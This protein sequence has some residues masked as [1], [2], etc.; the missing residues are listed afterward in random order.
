[1]TTKLSR[2]TR[3]WRELGFSLRVLNRMQFSAPW[4]R[5]NAKGC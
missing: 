4:H 1:M 2:L 3:F 5:G